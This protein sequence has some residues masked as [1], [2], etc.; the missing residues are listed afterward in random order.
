MKKQN[1]KIY[2]AGEDILILRL[3]KEYLP[4][5]H[6]VLDAGCGAG[7]NMKMLKEH[8]YVC[9]GVTISELEEKEAMSYGEVKMC[10]LETGLPK[11][12][13]E[14]KFDHF[15]AAHI[16]EHIFYPQNLLEDLRLTAK[17]GGIIVVPNILFWRNRV[18]LFFGIWEYE[19]IG[20]MDYTHSR[21]YS[22]RSLLK[23][24]KNAGFKIKYT[25]ATGGVFFGRG[26]YLAKL[27]DS[28]LLKLFPGLMGFQFYIV[29]EPS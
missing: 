13:L 15:I 9:S 2:V 20:L 12:F 14:R 8:G 22:Y 6:S 5:G 29:V 19:E 7:A 16:L 3:I 17:Y 28:V 27:I 21:W 18:K 11:D 26:G 4:K 10:N 1:E 25:E 24:L 23:T